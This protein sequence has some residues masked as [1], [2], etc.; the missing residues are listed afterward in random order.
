MNP[1]NEKA[2][3]LARCGSFYYRT[4]VD[5]S[6]AEAEFIS[7]LPGLVRVASLG[8]KISIAVQGKC[9]YQDYYKLIKF[10]DSDIDWNGTKA[11]LQARV[12]GG[13]GAI[14]TKLE[15]LSVSAARILGDT[16][17]ELLPEDLPEGVKAITSIKMQVLNTAPVIT[18]VYLQVFNII[19]QEGQ[20]DVVSCIATS[21]EAVELQAGKLAEWN[22]NTLVIGAADISETNKLLFQF[23]TTSDAA[24]QSATTVPSSQTVGVGAYVPS[25]QFWR[26]A[27]PEQS[28][29]TFN[30]P[31]QLKIEDHFFAGT[32][33]WDFLY[34]EG[35]PQPIAFPG[36]GD[37]VLPTT[38]ELIW[39]LHIDKDIMVTS[40]RKQDGTMMYANQDFATQFGKLTF[41]Q[42]PIALFPNMQFIAQ[43]YTGRMPNL[44]NY[45]VRADEVYGPIDRMMRYVR[46]SQSIKSL[47]HASA[48][49]AG[50][51]VVSEDCV[52]V[53]TSPLLDGLA[54][55]TT[56]GRYDAPYPHK[57]IALGTKLSKD[58][59]IGGMQLYRLIGPYDPMPSNVTGIELG[60]ALPVPGL[61]APNAEIEITDE[62]GNYRPKYEGTSDAVTAYHKYLE[63][64]AY[65]TQEPN[66]KENG[67]QHFRYTACA[68]RCV[69]ACIN[70]SYMTS[71]MKLRLMTY[72]RRELPIGSVLVT[73]KL[74]NIVDELQTGATGIEHALDAITEE[75]NKFIGEASYELVW[76]SEEN[77]LVIQTDSIPDA[78]FETVLD[79]IRQYTP[80]NLAIDTYN[81]SLSINWRATNKYA[82]CKTHADVVAINADYRNDLTT[83]G[84]W[85]YVLPEMTTFESNP[86]GDGDWWAGFFYKSP[87]KKIK[88]KFPKVTRC[89][90]FLGGANKVE[91]ADI[92]FPIAD[93]VSAL[94]RQQSALKK[95]R[96]IAPLA[97]S[98]EGCF[99]W[100]RVQKPDWYVYYPKTTNCS[101]MF[102][103]CI[104]HEEIKGEF[105]AEAT[106]LDSMYNKC[107]KLKVFPTYYPKASSADGMLNECQISKEIALAIINSF[108]THASGTHKVT[109]GIHVDYEHD[110]ELNAAIDLLNIE[111]TP[112]AEGGKGWTVVVQWNGTATASTASTFSLRRKPIYAKTR[113]ITLPDGETILELDWGHYV[114][115]W[116]ENGYQE[117]SSKEEA[118]EY[119]GVES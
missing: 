16:N 54:Y 100:A 106:N 70:E 26:L 72:L 4:L 60:A 88:A 22:F 62:L 8:D 59:V 87:L 109:L 46:G 105:G 30:R 78:S 80:L 115:N 90:A 50:L 37:V 42:N 21:S 11:A 41:L 51:A 44:Y 99:Y 85:V 66:K 56:K 53:A 82:M 7:H 94:Y 68:N 34:K 116:E 10:T 45:L 24:W 17:W 14:T 113:E 83:D 15:Q 38:Q 95:L 98:T 39:D 92:E 19:S 112:V 107:Q 77:K 40:I 18:P 5:E 32:D 31:A 84:E 108:P 89:H 55:I 69:V 119:F 103:E 93:R 71:Q 86:N 9:Y 117:F 43:S 1:L 114:T 57:P 20:A 79:I 36:D 12:S 28:L 49:A 104:Y 65:P 91:E 58:Y 64:G 101:G 81:H 67:I 96:I 29:A 97:T 61:V 35:T 76:L 2:N 6:K 33:T 73:A 75:L 27:A 110:E 63:S 23:A 118:K 48:Q 111:K 25:V 3:T 102:S 74:P 52:V 13:K 47:Y